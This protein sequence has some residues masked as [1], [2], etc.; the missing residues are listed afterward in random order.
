[1][2]TLNDSI[3][4]QKKPINYSDKFSVPVLSNFYALP[5]VKASGG[6]KS[7]PGKVYE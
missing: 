7:P 6:E 1:M 5:R 2:P 4:L 3:V